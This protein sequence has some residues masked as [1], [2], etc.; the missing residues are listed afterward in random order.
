MHQHLDASVLHLTTD[1]MRHPCCVS[2]I[3]II[4]RNIG[5]GINTYLYCVPLGYELTRRYIHVK[6]EFLQ[7]TGH[8]CYRVKIDINFGRRFVVLIIIDEYKDG[9]KRQ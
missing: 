1:G 3:R 5:I 9:L 4:N 8:Q 2:L 7:G 6:L